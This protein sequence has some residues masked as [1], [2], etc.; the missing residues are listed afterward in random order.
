MP[1]EALGKGQDQPADGLGL[2]LICYPRLDQGS[3]VSV[4]P[5]SIGDP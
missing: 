1:I 5:D 4:I 3:M 2:A